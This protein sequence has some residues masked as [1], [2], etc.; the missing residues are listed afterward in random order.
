MLSL[1]SMGRKQQ[2][3]GQEQGL[4]SSSA[5]AAN[6]MNE[7]ELARLRQVTETQQKQVEML[8]SDRAPQVKAGPQN[9]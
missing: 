7:Q 3:Q 5:F 8:R 9:A 4:S 1:L 6:T 2:M